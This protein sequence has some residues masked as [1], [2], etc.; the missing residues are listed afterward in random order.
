MKFI[1]LTRFVPIRSPIFLSC[2]ICF[3][4]NSFDCRLDVLS[5]PLWVRSF[6]V[7]ALASSMMDFVRS[8]ALRLLAERGSCSNPLVHTVIESLPFLRHLAIVHDVLPAVIASYYL[9]KLLLTR[10]SA[11]VR[12]FSTTVLETNQSLIDPINGHEGFIHGLSLRTYPFSSHASRKEA[13][14]EK[15]AIVIVKGDP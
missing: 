9:P 5:S 2:C 7:F 11:L 1:S 14:L 4:G 6:A 10:H 12:T 8:V 3:K 15:R 13:L